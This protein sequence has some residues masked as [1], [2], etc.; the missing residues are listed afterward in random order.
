V[1]VVSNT[2]GHS[3]FGTRSL[4]ISNAIT[5]SSYNDQTFS[6]SLADE[7]GETSAST[8]TYSGGT[9]QPYFEAQ[10]DFAST[11]PGSEQPGL[12]VVAS[13]D[14]GDPS[15]MSWLQMQDTPSGLQLNFQ[16]YQHSIGN[17]VLTPIATGLDRT[18][19]HTV[20]MTM[21]F[22]DGQANDVVKVYL[23][24]TLIQTGTNW[25]D[26]YRDF[27]GGIPHAVDSILFRVGGT[28][29]PATMGNG[30]LIDNFTSYSGPVPTA[31]LTSLS[32]SSGA[33]S[34]AFDPAVSAYSASVGN[35]TTGVGVVA[36]ASPGATALITGGSN[37]AVGNNMIMITVT[38]A[39]GTTVKTYAITVDRAV[40]PATVPAPP[41]PTPPAPAAS[42][43][44]AA[45]QLRAP[46]DLAGAVQGGGSLLLS[47][48]PPP[49]GLPVAQYTVWKDGVAIGVTPGS[50]RELRVSGVTVG[51]ASGFEVSADDGNGN[52]SAR[53]PKLTGVPDLTG[54]T[55]DQA[56]ALTTSRGFA[57]GTVLT[58]PSSAAT[59]TTIGQEPSPLPAYRV[60]GTAID[61]VVSVHAA[62]SAPLVVKVASARRIPI[63]IRH[64]LTPLILTTIASEARISL[65]GYRQ[66]HTTYAT[67]SRSL[68]A[69][70]NYLTLRLPSQLN[71][72]LP[73]VYRLTFKVRTH[74]QAKL[75]S[76]PVVLS[77]RVLD[78][79]LPKREAD[80]LLV[81]APSISPSVAQLSGRYLVKECDTTTVFTATR[82]PNE[83]VGAV[84][85]DAQGAGL[86]TIRHLHAVFPDLRIVAI[87]R[88]AG[89]S[90]SARATGAWRTVLGTPT[91]DLLTARLMRAL[92]AT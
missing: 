87:V 33:L 53:S 76:V 18:V 21:Q 2:Y 15:R 38:A 44:P 57:V 27:A 91:A 59:G 28:A 60:L 79:P 68:H 88:S 61:I 81:A 43:T 26:Y 35:G 89:A 42:G 71:V 40:P 22:L 6:P 10:W 77:S 78:A 31:D 64:A 58:R 34:P 47:W 32:L 23:D 16:D 70:S 84:V 55:I 69:G 1:G 56:R 5:C 50:S 54:L 12:S 7:A 83:R 92:R 11:V 65:T 51:D 86:T 80:V 14:R 90:R 72:R 39:D 8:S 19:P 20:K 9:R 3:T 45:P 85:L 29:A 13:A 37:L 46:Q 75:Y 49:G 63:G 67:W 48:D 74:D 30:F 82:A 41:A 62:A 52:A 66:I 73:G 25:E 24:G 17:F 36:G 4:R